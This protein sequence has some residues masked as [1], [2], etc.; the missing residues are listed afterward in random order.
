MSKAEAVEVIQSKYQSFLPYLNER[1]RRV[2]AA[3]EA[4]ALGRGGITQV[5]QTKGL[6]HT[7]IY[8][9]IKDKVPKYWGEE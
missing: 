7:T 6:S 3:I 9:G 2:W 1:A 4:H 8:A 5:A